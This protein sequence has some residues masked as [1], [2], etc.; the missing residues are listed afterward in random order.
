MSKRRLGWA[1]AIVLGV[2]GIAGAAWNTMSGGRI[3][4]TAAQ[5][6]ERINRSLP[7]EFKGVTV[8]AAKVEIAEGRIALHVAVHAAA[9]GRSFSAAA[10]ARGVP[11]YDA[12]RGMLFFD[13]DDVEVTNVKAS[14]SLTGALEDR[15]GGLLK[16]AVGKLVAAGIKAYLDARPVYRFKDDVKGILLKATVSNIAIEGGL[17]V[18]T[19]S[20]LNLTAMGALCLGLAILALIL[21]IYL[22]R[23]P[24]A[25]RAGGASHPSVSSALLSSAEVER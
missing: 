8:D 3:T 20:L 7:R 9:L 1:I 10:S 14:G 21:V 2:I 17:L 5:L 12:A 16:E 4:F 25:P 24:A 11:V 15:F 23:H 19:V 13:A 18:I 22:M 6:Q